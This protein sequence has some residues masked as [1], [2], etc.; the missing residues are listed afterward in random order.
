[1]AGGIGARLINHGEMY[2][3]PAYAITAITESHYVSAES[4]QAYKAVFD[5]LGLNSGEFD[6]ANIQ[7]K[8]NFRDILKEANAREHTIFS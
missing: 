3:I 8:A 5:R 6:S 7:K 1:M 2:G 4:M